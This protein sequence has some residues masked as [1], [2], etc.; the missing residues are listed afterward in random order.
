MLALLCRANNS[1]GQTGGTNSIKE[2]VMEQ[3]FSA[4][5]VVN[6]WPRSLG[7]TCIYAD[8]DC[9]RFKAYAP[10]SDFLR[11]RYMLSYSG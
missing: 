10:R 4:V 5:F 3:T 2:Q 7:T 9:L 6:E 8:P 1:E 11:L